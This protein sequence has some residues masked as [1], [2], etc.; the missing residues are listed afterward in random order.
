MLPN[1]AGLHARSA[2]LLVKA[3][4]G[5]DSQVILELEGRQANARSLVELLRLGARQ[6]HKVC[7]RVEGGD[8]KEALQTVRTMIENGFDEG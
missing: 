1:A 3:V 7:I 6:G 4:A 8:A 5:F 2:A